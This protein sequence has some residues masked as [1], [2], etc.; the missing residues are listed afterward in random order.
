L[1]LILEITKRINDLWE[2]NEFQPIIIEGWNGF[3]KS[4]YADNAIAE[5]HSI[6]GKYGNWDVNVFKKFSGFHPYRVQQKWTARSNLRRRTIGNKPQFHPFDK[7]FHWDDAGAWI[8]AL[9]YNDPYVKYVGKYLQTARTDWG[10]L[11]FTCIDSEDIAKKVRVFSSGITVKITKE[12]SN[13]THKWTRTAVA[14]HREKDWYGNIY[15]VD[16]WK[17]SFSCYMPDVFYRWYDP[18]RRRYAEMTKRLMAREMRN[19]DDIMKTVRYAN[20]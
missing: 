6:D 12:G 16:D 5:L 15:W 20:M 3:G 11:I 2:D 19:K 7:A 9:D 8:H 10:A 4:A 1:I 18:I 17:E 14:K 13:S